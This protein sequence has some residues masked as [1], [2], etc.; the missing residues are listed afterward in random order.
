MQHASA[1]RRTLH[2]RILEIS[3]EKSPGAKRCAAMHL[4][5]Q[6]QIMEP[7]GIEPL[8]IQALRSGTAD[9]EWVR[10]TVRAINTDPTLAQ[11]IRSWPYLATETREAIRSLALAAARIPEPSVCH[12][13]SPP[14]LAGV[15][16]GFNTISRQGGGASDTKGGS[17]RFDAA[18]TG[19]AGAGASGGAP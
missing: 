4:R 18:A 15:V 13:T 16:S 2:N 19:I 11:L 12:Q 10:A 1:P 9:S 6:P 3:L 17:S 5:A 14:T 7:G 8:P